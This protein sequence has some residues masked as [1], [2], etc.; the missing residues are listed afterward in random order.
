MA[1]PKQSR[2]SN[3]LSYTESIS[4]YILHWKRYKF[5]FQAQF[6]FWLEIS[7]YF[8]RSKCIHRQQPFTHMDNNECGKIRGGIVRTEDIDFIVF[9]YTMNSIPLHNVMFSIIIYY[10]SNS[11]QWFFHD[12]LR[13]IS[14][15][16]WKNLK[17]V[18]GSRESAYYA[19]HT[20]TE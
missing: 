12:N 3:T 16:R 17:T 1:L 11:S 18:R 5:S 7:S 8:T 20:Q 19:C 14:T 2:I 10:L 13:L 15:G 9:A 6:V 4:R